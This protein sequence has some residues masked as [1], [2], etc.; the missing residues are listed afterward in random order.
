[1][2]RMFG[3]D[4]VTSIPWSHT[5]L[6]FPLSGCV[7]TFTDVSRCASVKSSLFRKAVFLHCRVFSPWPISVSFPCLSSFSSC[8]IYPSLLLLLVILNLSSSLTGPDVFACISVRVCVVIILMDAVLPWPGFCFYEEK[9]NR[10][11]STLLIL[12]SCCRS[13]PNFLRWEQQGWKKSNVGLKAF[14]SSRLS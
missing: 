14:W 13:C 11:Y 4:T 8:P 12:F 3:T 9:S 2:T 6:W 10:T 5:R 7:G 1:M